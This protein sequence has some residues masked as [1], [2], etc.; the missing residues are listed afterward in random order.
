MLQDGDVLR[1]IRRRMG[2][3]DTL[4]VLGVESGGTGATTKEGAREN[5][6][7]DEWM[8]EQ[9]M[10]VKGATVIAKGSVEAPGDKETKAV[11]T[12]SGAKCDGKAAQ[13][14][15]DAVVIGEDGF[16]EIGI[17]GTAGA[18]VGESYS[19]NTIDVSARFDIEID[20][21]S[22][23]SKS[24]TANVSN[25]TESLVSAFAGVEK[26]EVFLTAGS[27]VKFVATVT[28]ELWNN[29]NYAEVDIIANVMKI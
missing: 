10:H 18:R 9:I 28:A 24:T 19:S 8:E 16:Y 5:L 22:Y 29:T 25:K 11:A 21:V 26:T 20:G 23:F 7:L 15:G 17:S 3:G 14:A 6:G 27:S 4:G 13:V 1:M 2:L 12:L